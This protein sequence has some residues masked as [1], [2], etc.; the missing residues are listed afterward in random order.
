MHL[1]GPRT[2]D[3]HHMIDGLHIVTVR[4]EHTGGVYEMFEIVAERG[5]AAPP[6]AAPWSA[7]LFLIDGTLTVTVDGE[8]H[9]IDRGATVTFPAHTFFTWAVT[10]T[11]ARMVAV[12]SGSGAGRFFADMAAAIPPDRPIEEAFAAI[13]E[14]TV[15]H[16][17][18]LATGSAS[19]AG[20][21]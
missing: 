19:P 1:T 20:Q 7:S 16:G 8:V 12:T 11:A 15:R 2:G 13:A 10:S 14:V 18:R 21:A 17:V 6:H 3:H 4:P 9:E 5:P